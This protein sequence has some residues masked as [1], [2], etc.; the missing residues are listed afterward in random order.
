VLQSLDRVR[1]AI[2]CHTSIESL[3]EI[4]ESE[5]IAVLMLSMALQVLV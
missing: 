2:G 1:E 5:V 3:W 4:C